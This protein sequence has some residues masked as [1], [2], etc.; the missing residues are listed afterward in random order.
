MSA[1]AVVAG[2][3]AQLE[4][5]EDVVVPG[6]KVGTT[7]STALAALVHRDELVVVQL[8][9][10]NDALALAV[11]ALDV[12]A[13][14]ADCGPAPAEA[15]SPFGEVSIFRDTAMHDGLDAVADLDRGSRRRAGNGECLN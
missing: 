1:T 9:E 15:A 12:A 5:V 10:R 11:G 6:L 2:V 13:G 8:E 4:E 14:A 3:L 7:G